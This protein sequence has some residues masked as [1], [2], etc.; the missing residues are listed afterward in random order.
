[1][2]STITNYSS[3]INEH[4]PIPGVDN[5]TSGFRNNFGYIKNA[6]T[7]TASEIENLQ[8]NYA[9]ILSN[10]IFTATNIVTTGTV[11]ASALIAT[12][13]VST[14]TITAT[15]INANTVT[16]STIISPGTINADNFIA[17]NSVSATVVLSTLIV[18]NNMLVGNGN[19]LTNVTSFATNPPNDS[20]G[21]GTHKKGM[22]YANTTSLYICFADYTDGVDPIWVGTAGTTSF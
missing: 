19:S 18:A 7:A 10:T 21:D 16:A 3:N 13:I 1:M 14:G 8:L 12:N 15:N 9:G 11:T 6:F 5:D 4:F 2:A 20:R 22:V 17:G